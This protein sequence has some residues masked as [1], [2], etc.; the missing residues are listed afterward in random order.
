ML[1]LRR[2]TALL[3]HQRRIRLHDALRHQIVQPEQVLVLAQT[4]EVAPAEGKRAEGFVDHV[5]EV[6]GRGEAQVDVWRVGG[7]GVV[8]A[9]ELTGVSLFAR[10]ARR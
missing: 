6:L 9:L 5:Q 10:E 1:E 7:F 2:V 3:V 8:G 4:V